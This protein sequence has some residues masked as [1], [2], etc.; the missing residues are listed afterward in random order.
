[1]IIGETQTRVATV[2][3]SLEREKWETEKAFRER[4]VA[5]K[6]REQAVLETEL[7]LKQA[8]H[9]TSRWK[10]PLVVAILAAAVAAIGNAFVAYTNG[11]SQIKLEAQKAEQTRILEMIKTGDPDKAAGNLHFLLEAGL[12]LDPGTREDLKKYLKNLK[13][14][15]GPA[16]PSASGVKDLREFVSEFEGA[17]LKPYKDPTGR[18]FIGS[19]HV[20]TDDEIRSGTIS[21]DGKVVDWRSGITE[22]QANWLLDQDLGPIRKEIERLV[23]VKLTQNQRDALTSFAFNIGLGAFSRS[24]LLRKLNAGKY[25]EVPDEMMRYGKM[26]MRTIPGMDKRRQSEVALWNKQ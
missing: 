8:E 19:S 1:M 2:S 5:V 14:G 13:P 20:L 4:E 11:T 21:I 6:E 26:G 7:A 12:I 10:N 23:K 17:L 9:A 3:D 22:E 16:L 24:S 18:T 15:S 25:E